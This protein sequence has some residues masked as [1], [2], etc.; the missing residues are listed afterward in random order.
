MC[1]SIRSTS[2]N[3]IV[4]LSLSFGRIASSVTAPARVG[5]APDGRRVVGAGDGHRHQ[6]VDRAAVAVV[7]RDGEALGRGLAQPPGTAWRCWPRCRSSPPCRRRPRSPRHRCRSVSVP[8]SVLPPAAATLVVCTSIRSTSLK[9]IVP[10]SL[11]VGRLRP[12][13]PPRSR[14]RALMVGA[15]LVPVM[16]TV[17]SWSTVPPLPSLI[18]TVNALGRGLAHAPGTAWRCW[19]R[20]RS[21]P[22]CRAR[23]RRPLRSPRPASAC[24]P[25]CCRRRRDAGGVHV[26]QVDVV[27][28][29]RAG[30]A[31]RSARSRPRSPRRSHRRARDGRRV[32]G[33]G[34]GHRH[35]LVDRA[36]VAVV[37]RDG[38]GLGRGLAQPPGTA[39][40]CWPRCRSSP[41]CRPPRRRCRRCSPASACRPA[42]CRPP[43]RWWCARRSGR[44]R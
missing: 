37:D 26:D 21:S 9:A 18:V 31:Q 30:V 28:G 43:P 35:Q 17:T 3:A 12:R 10:L 8:P 19:P 23:R 13:S 38:E 22:P 41:P 16:V 20:C 36:A 27:E 40:R 33:A 7:D 14:R 24:R 34:D 44:R 4:P 25:A 15:S 1:T 29:D 32:I 11:S 42:C 6:L 39:W 2:L 5:R